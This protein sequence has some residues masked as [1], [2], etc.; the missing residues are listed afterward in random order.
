MSNNESSAEIAAFFQNSKPRDFPKCYVDDI[1]DK[2][3]WELCK[4]TNYPEPTMFRVQKNL[5]LVSSAQIIGKL[6]E[7]CDGEEAS[8]DEI[9]KLYKTHPNQFE[10]LCE[11]L[12]NKEGFKNIATKLGEIKKQVE[13]QS[14][15]VP[16]NNLK[17]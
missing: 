7:F 13:E 10:T 17:I 2:K 9:S 12:K 3:G 8:V 5:N 15:E 11:V 16:K 1:N 14:M 6:A 4:N